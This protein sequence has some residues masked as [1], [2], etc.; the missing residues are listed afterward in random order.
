MHRLHVYSGLERPPTAA[1]RQPG[2]ARG[3]PLSAMTTRQATRAMADAQQN[4]P[5]IMLIYLHKNIYFTLVS[6]L[7]YNLKIG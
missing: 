6:D 1:S 4:V 3:P 7:Y 2:R 5:Q